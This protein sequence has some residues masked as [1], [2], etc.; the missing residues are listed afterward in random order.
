MNERGNFL[1]IILIVFLAAMLLPPL[2]MILIPQADI[3]M[4]IV[5]IFVLFSTVRGYLGDG[6]PTL[7]ITAVLV[8]ILVIKWAFLTASLY[9]TLTIFLGFGVFSMFL[10]M[11]NTLVRGHG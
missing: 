3:I 11:L 6:I 8:Y 2:I 4:R 1:I 7:L 9:V 5:L 10:W